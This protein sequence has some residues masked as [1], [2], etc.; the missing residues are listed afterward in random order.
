[1]QSSFP[2]ALFGS[3]GFQLL[4]SVTLR[5]CQELLQYHL[6]STASWPPIQKWVALCAA[7]G[8]GDETERHEGWH[9]HWKEY[10]IIF[11]VYSTEKTSE[12]I[13]KC[14]MPKSAARNYTFVTQETPIS[15][16]KFRKHRIVLCGHILDLDIDTRAQHSEPSINVTL[17]KCPIGRTRHS[18]SLSTSPKSPIPKNTLSFTAKGQSSRSFTAKGQSSRKLAI[19]RSMKRDP[20]KLNI[21]QSV[22]VTYLILDKKSFSCL[23]CIS[24]KYPPKVLHLLCASVQSLYSAT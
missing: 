20:W 5:L 4:Y 9:T 22:S 13:L 10:L 8:G 6:P 14:R 18:A 17:H 15:T 11:K 19:V 16:N 24:A 3:L 1:M 21:N 23:L 7:L 2:S 12:I